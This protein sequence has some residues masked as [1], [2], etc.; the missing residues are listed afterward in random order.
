MRQLW[1]RLR[2]VLRQR[3]LEA[4]L[5]EE[6]EHH[7]ELTR[8]ALQAD[9]T[10]PTALE[11]ET[12][13]AIGNALL[14]R[15]QARDVWVWP[16]L[17]DAVQDARFAGRLF[18]AE[19]AFAGGAVLALALGL[20]ATA[21]VFSIVNAVL[22]RALPFEAPDEIVAI[23]TAERHGP[24]LRGP[25][26]YRGLSYSD[27]LSWRGAS[28][29]I[30]VA[31]YSDGAMS[32]ADDG[33]APEHLDGAYLSANTFG[34]LGYTPVIGRGFER[35][36]DRPGAPSVTLLAHDTWMRRYAGDTTIIGRAIRINGT[37][38]TVVGYLDRIVVP[39][40][41]RPLAATGAVAACV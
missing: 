40:T 21:T 11:R 1:R 24:P 22:L 28:D 17:Q 31:A 2:Y 12:S 6:L 37:P 36:D 14:A 8:A 9:G 4:E 18:A 33:A 15:D 34:L 16:W 32:L 30:E 19:R 39:V 10:H 7:R 13:R 3:R 25:E 38:S 23:G 27:Y 5:D 26:D 29:V 41:R 35:A 20:G